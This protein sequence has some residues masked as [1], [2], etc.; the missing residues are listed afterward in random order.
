ML[1]WHLSEAGK[2]TRKDKRKK[3]REE[4]AGS[5][6]DLHEKM[7]CTETFL[8]ITKDNGYDNLSVPENWVIYGLGLLV[9]VHVVAFDIA[10]MRQS[11]NFIELITRR[12]TVLQ[13]KKPKGGKAGFFYFA[14]Q[15]K[16]KQKGEEEKPCIVSQKS[17]WASLIKNDA[18]IKPHQIGR[19][20]WLT[21][22]VL[23]CLAGPFA[24]ASFYCTI[25]RKGDIC[26]PTGNSEV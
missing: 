1:I 24:P 2:F 7:W 4:E 16:E 17:N 3:G 18:M 11:N 26:V 21:E 20:T 22:E 23:P 9:Y 25:N 13:W 15:N 5:D 19:R 6:L 8:N 14:M 12:F 10:W